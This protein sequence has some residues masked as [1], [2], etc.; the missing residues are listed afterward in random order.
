MKVERLKVQSN[1]VTFNLLAEQPATTLL[2][3]YHVPN[4]LGQMD[5]RL[6]KLIRANAKQKLQNENN[7]RDRNGSANGCLHQLE[8]RGEYQPRHNQCSEKDN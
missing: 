8:Q 6:Q 1:L 4:G 3:C 7:D 5:D 2:T